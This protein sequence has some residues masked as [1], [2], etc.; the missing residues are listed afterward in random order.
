MNAGV[1][2]LTAHTD[3]T[4]VRVPIHP[5][6]DGATRTVVAGDPFTEQLV[7]PS[8]ALGRAGPQIT[9]ASPT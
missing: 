2:Y 7:G 1:A 5:G 9:A 4:I 3:N 6:A 8:S